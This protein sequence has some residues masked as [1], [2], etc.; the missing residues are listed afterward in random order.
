MAT[1]VGIMFST[2]RPSQ[3]LGFPMSSSGGSLRRHRH[4]P[5]GV[6]RGTTERRGGANLQ[7]LNYGSLGEL[8]R[9]WPQQRGA[10]TEIF[11]NL[12]MDP[13]ESLCGPGHNRK[14]RRR[15]SSKT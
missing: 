13:S 11:K 8:L 9:S 2:T 3:D 15:E 7:K 5:G 14:V 10:V 12:T 6:F 4:G 1:V